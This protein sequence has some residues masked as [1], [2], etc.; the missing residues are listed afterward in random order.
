MGTRYK[1]TKKEKNALNT[2]IKLIRSS[3]SVR[4]RINEFAVKKGLTESQFSALD[5]LYY[6]GPLNQKELGN[7]LFR[8]GGNITLI[9]DNLE[10]QKLVR[11]ERGKDRRSFMLHLTKQGKNLFERLFPEQLRLIKEEMNLLSD[12]EQV[13][14]QK[15]CKILGLK[16]RN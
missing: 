4:S 1:G 13:Q 6:L 3:E 10:K 9:I 16:K 12:D 2:Y 8:T 5:A 7:K 11:R 14:M 15:F